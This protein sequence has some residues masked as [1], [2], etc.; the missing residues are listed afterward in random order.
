[1]MNASNESVLIASHINSFLNEYVPSQK[2]RRSHALKSYHDTLSLYP[3]FLE[4]E[5]GLHPNSF[6]SDCFSVLFIEEW[7]VWLMESR[8][9]SAETCNNRLASLRAFLNHLG[10][11]DI[12]F[13]FLSQSASLVPRRKIQSK[14]VQGMSSSSVISYTRFDD[15][16][17]T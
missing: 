13:L 16:N 14:K 3:G 10:S 4:T 2:S 7:L 12:S 15:K 1:M 17:R 9:C 5:K 8:S 11:R 6:C